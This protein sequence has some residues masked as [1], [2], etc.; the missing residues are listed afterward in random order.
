MTR[1]STNVTSATPSRVG[2]INRKRL[3]RYFVTLFG[4]P[5]RVELVVQVVARRDR[6]ALHL[7]QGGN[8]PVPLQRVDHVGLV[9]E[10][11]LLELTQD[12]LSLLDVGGAALFGHQV[13]ADRVLWAGR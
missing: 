9:V 2:S 4:Q 13:F 11:P 8:D 1:M 3:I 5:H 10:Q 12:L 7:R 6:P